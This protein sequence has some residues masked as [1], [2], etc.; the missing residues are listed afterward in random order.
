MTDSKFTALIP[1]RGGSKG[2]VGKNVKEIC[3]KPLIAWTI[4]AAKMSKNIGRVI[5]STDCPVIANVAREYGAEIPFIRPEK[6]ALDTSSAADVIRHMASNI[7]GKIESLVFLQPTS[8]LRNNEH[9]DEAIELFKKNE[10]YSLVSV[11]ESDKSPYWT[12]W[13]EGGKLKPLL[14]NNYEKNRRRQ[15]V[16]KAYTLNGAIYIFNLDN[17]LRDELFLS[18]SSSYYLMDKRSSVD[19]DDI[20]DF[21]IAEAIMGM[22]GE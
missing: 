15:D 20:I 4:I 9:I 8:P 2:L 7:S 6:H 14:S 5:V 13:I 12:Y 10:C 3:G 17:F 16:E 21:K 1:A 19:I 22:G 18:D 11:V